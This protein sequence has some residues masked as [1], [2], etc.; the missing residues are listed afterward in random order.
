MNAIAILISP[1]V[2]FVLFLAAAGLLYLL[3]KRM[4]PK[5]TRVGGKLETYANYLRPIEKGD[6]VWLFEIVGWPR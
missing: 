6:D 4:A 1:P 3:G 2:A 5:L